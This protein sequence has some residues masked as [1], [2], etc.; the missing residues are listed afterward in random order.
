MNH[1]ILGYIWRDRS[2]IWR[3]LDPKMGIHKPTKG[4][5][6]TTLAVGPRSSFVQ[7]RCEKD[8]QHAK[9]GLL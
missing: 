6:I 2:L 4:L 8:T 9:F 7:Q 5:C 3:G 1:N